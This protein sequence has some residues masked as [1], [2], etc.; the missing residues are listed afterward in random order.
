MVSSL[1]SQAY[2]EIFLLALRSLA[3]GHLSL[4]SVVFGSGVAA[5]QAPT[6][7]LL[8]V[9]G[10]GFA[11][12]IITPHSRLPPSLGSLALVWESLAMIVLVCEE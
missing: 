6:L 7:I 12:C 8:A 5:H 9:C 3:S 1:L 11:G 10:A 4:G 2:R